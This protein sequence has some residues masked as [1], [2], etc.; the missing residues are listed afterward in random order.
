MDR[1]RLSPAWDALTFIRLTK[2]SLRVSVFHPQHLKTRSVCQ[3]M[4]P[5]GMFPSSMAQTSVSSIH[6]LLKTTWCDA[7]SLKHGTAAPRRSFSPTLLILTLPKRRDR[8]RYTALWFPACALN[9]RCLTTNHI[10]KK[11][12]AFL[13]RKNLLR[14]TLNWFM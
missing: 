8:I 3:Y 4:V 10:K 12:S 5:V 6:G 11:Q 2:K 14:K 7:P 1:L 9:R 13:M